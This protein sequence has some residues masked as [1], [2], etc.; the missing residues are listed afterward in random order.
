MAIIE[1]RPEVAT[2]AAVIARSPIVVAQAAARRYLPQN[3]PEG[4]EEVDVAI[5]DWIIAETRLIGRA[6]H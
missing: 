4:F 5:L 1:T 2:L 3:L 6:L